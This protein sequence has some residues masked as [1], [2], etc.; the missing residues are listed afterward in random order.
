MTYGFVDEH[1]D[2]GINYYRLKSIDLDGRFDYSEIRSLV[3]ERVEIDYSIFPNPS[4][5]EV[6][7]ITGTDNKEFKIEVFSIGGK[8]VF[9]QSGLST[10]MDFSHLEN[11]LYMV[12]ISQ[13]NN[14]KVINWIK[15]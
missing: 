1:L 8:K 13:A 7:N 9:S 11:G 14:L 2:T 5:G 15:N 6:M 3:G 12:S 4:N 10:E